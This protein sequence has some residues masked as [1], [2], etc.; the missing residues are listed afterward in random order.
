M[1]LRRGLFWT[2]PKPGEVTGKDTT[3]CWKER[4]ETRNNRDYA[5]DSVRHQKGMAR[6]VVLSII[7]SEMQ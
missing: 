1:P 2:L 7:E 6:S 4:H 3:W 5:P